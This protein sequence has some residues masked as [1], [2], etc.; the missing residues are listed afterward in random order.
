MLHEQGLAYQA[1]AIVNYDPVDKTVLANEQV[2][3]N[4]FSWRSGAKV[5]KIKLKQWFFRITAFKEDL[6]KDL[7]TLTGGWPDRVLSQQR[8]WI[9]KSTGAKIKF[10]VLSSDSDTHGVDV[11]V[12]TTRPD[13]LYGV[14]YLALSLDHPLVSAAAK[15]DPALQNFLADAGSFSPDSKAGYKLA[16]ITA[17]HPLKMI[18][19]E[20]QILSRKLPVFVAPYVLNSYGEGAVMGVPG[21]DAR[22]LA[23]VKENLN[24]KFINMVIQP[25]PTPDNDA[26]TSQVPIGD[27]K[28]FTQEGF[29]A[30]ACWK[31]QGLSSNEAARQIVQDLELIERAEEAESWRLRDWLISRQR[32]WGT[33]IPIIHCNGCGAIPVP[34]DQLPVVLPGI[35]G[36]WLKGKKGNPLESA[37]EWL[38]TKC[39]SCGGPAKRDTDTMDTFVDSSW[40]YLRHLDPH[41]KNSPVSPALARPVDTYVGGV[42]HAI[43]HL[44]YA[45][46]IYK[47]LSKSSLFPELTL[48]SEQLDPPPSEPFRKLLSQGM[49]HGITYSDPSTGRFLLPSELDL[50]NPGKPLIKDTMVAP[51]ISFEKMSKSKHN[52]VDP[53]ACVLKYGADATRAHILFSAP[54]GEVLE[55]D[56]N[57]IVGIE[58][59]FNRLWRVV[60]DTRQRLLQEDFP[61]DA[62]STSQ[63]AHTFP[64]PPLLQISDA[65]ADAILSTH[66]TIISITQCLEHNP[67]ALN[68]VVSDLTKL[69]NTLAS[70]PPTSPTILYVCVSSLLRLLA[71][72]APALSSEC[73]EILHT[74]GIL[75]G[76]E[77]TRIQSRSQFDNTSEDTASLIPWSWPEPLLTSSE[78][79]S[80]SQRGGQTVAVQI[81]GKLRFSVTIPR[82]LSSSTTRTTS[83][84]VPLSSSPSTPPPDSKMATGTTPN[85]DKQNWIVS[86][87]LETKEGQIWLRQ[88]HDWDKRRRVVVANG[89]KVMN[90]VF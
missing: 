87:I 7:D 51:N 27:A 21:H 72:V 22:D 14:E 64:L 12:F 47:F 35:G 50:S 36:E 40:Y 26:F 53:T 74:G 43:L 31:Y 29:L 46:F 19:K 20:S 18:D 62:G 54:A 61:V 69:T 44:L 56:E 71:P 34:E 67:Y 63:T 28:A 17:T 78:A 9:G 58:R 38:H 90:V 33:P 42:E 89:G 45:R 10:E 37:T 23:F 80:L 84:T 4:G 68:T 13:T 32:Y 48:A 88:K 41:N 49:V 24:P 60:M 85:E 11:H 59:V 75:L 25:E 70:S 1:E 66:R 77:E 2:D 55:W 57:K 73:W 79:L 65:D 39:P 30:P 6:L 52:G 3:A 16:N 5:E 15:E 83:T 8:H 86:H 76:T 81:N 82:M